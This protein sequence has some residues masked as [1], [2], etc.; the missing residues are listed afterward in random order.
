MNM[1]L[2]A[3]IQMAALQMPYRRSLKAIFRSLTI[4][5]RLY[6]QALIRSLAGRKGVYGSWVKPVMS[7]LAVCKSFRG[8]ALD[9]FSYTAERKAERA[10]LTRYEVYLMMLPRV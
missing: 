6:F 4:W 10:A 3:F 1:K 5:R 9:L 8:T 2:P 7:V